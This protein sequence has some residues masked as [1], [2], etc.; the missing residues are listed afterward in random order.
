MKLKS[1]ILI[2]AFIVLAVTFAAR[3]TA[4]QQVTLCHRPPG[5]P[6]NA[7][8]ITV[9]QPA[10]QNHFAHGDTPGPCPGSPKK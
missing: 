8:T 4:Q 1:L 10:A 9:G 2:L 6:S 5:N 3:I 7:Q